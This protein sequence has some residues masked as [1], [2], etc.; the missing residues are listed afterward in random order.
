[1]YKIISILIL[2]LAGCA[3]HTCKRKMVIVPGITWEYFSPQ[4]SRVISTRHGVLVEGNVFIS[5]HEYG[6]DV[7]GREKSVYVD[8][9]DDVVDDTE[10]T[11]IRI[12]KESGY[13]GMDAAS[14]MGIFT[15][16]SRDDYNVKMAELMK[17]VSDRMTAD[18]VFSGTDN[19]HF[20][21]RCHQ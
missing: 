7:S 19:K 2:V 20:N 3:E 10:E 4:Y 5:F 14:A 6:F 13:G 15:R 21:L 11:M 16:E 1:M 8:L 17:R 9:I 12:S 18:S